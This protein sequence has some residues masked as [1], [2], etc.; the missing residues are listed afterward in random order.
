VRAFREASLKG[1]Q[2]AMDH[3]E[4]MVDLILRDYNTQNK[5][6]AQLL[7]EAQQTAELMHPELIEVGHTNPGRWQHMADT[8]AELGMMPADFN[9]KGLLYDP[10]PQ[11]DYTHYY[12]VMTILVL[13]ALAALV[14]ILPLYRLNV[15]LRHIIDHER[16][17]Q[18]ELRVAKE[19]AEAASAAN[20]RYLAVITHEVR[21]PLSGII[22]LAGMLRDEPLSAEQQKMLAVM[23]TTGEDMLR[24]INDVLEYSKIEEGRLQLELTSVDVAPFLDAINQLFQP[25]AREKSLDLQV[26]L[27]PE[28]P[29]VILTDVLRLRG[30]LR[31]LLSNAIKFTEAGAVTIEVSAQPE[32]STAAAP[33]PRWRW[34]F[35]VRDTGIGIAREHFDAL[36]Q[37]Y[38]QAHSGIARSFGGTGLGLAIS[39]QLARL[40][41]G[42]LKL[43][44]SSPGNGSTFIL[45]IVTGENIPVASPALRSSG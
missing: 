28:A 6:R 30:I 23:Q 41:G 15:Q 44:E 10:N 45:E 21:T 34:R 35:A 8:Y 12:W 18:V 19:A 9:L 14:W 26:R 32:P 3:Q 25:L 37:P 2:Y 4:E 13:I 7:F 11:P 16:A 39:R 43:A 22:S 31:N 1:W 33:G 42:D 29:R 20:T 17:L 27:S 24:L 5:T 40:L 36:F 38:A